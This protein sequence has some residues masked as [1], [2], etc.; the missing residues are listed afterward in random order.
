MRIK[1]KVKVDNAKLL[2]A[3]AAIRAAASEAMNDI[4]DDLVRASSGA[5]PHD[6]GVLEKSWNKKVS[7]GFL[8]SFAEVSYSAHE[9]GFNYAI[10]MHEGSYNLGPGSLAKPGGQGMSGTHYSVGP[11]FLERPL[12]GEREAYSNHFRNHIAAALQALN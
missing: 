10:M 7:V 11:K 6:K 2:A 3:P 4:A 9:K 1:V 8:R 12:M 5:A